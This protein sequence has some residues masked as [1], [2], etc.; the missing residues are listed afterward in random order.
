MT[1]QHLGEW[2][3]LSGRGQFLVS[4]FKDYGWYLW[5]CDEFQAPRSRPGILTEIFEWKFNKSWIREIWL[6]WRSAWRIITTTCAWSAPRTKIPRRCWNRW[7]VASTPSHTVRCSA[8]TP[9]LLASERHTIIADIIGPLTHVVIA[10]FTRPSS[11]D[12]CRR[13]GVFLLLFVAVFYAIISHEIAV[14]WHFSRTRGLLEVRFTFQ[15][16]LRVSVIK[17]SANSFDLI[18]FN[19]GWFD[20]IWY[21]LL[22]Y[23]I[24]V[25]S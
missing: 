10:T 9:T 25:S 5:V 14:V 13:K 23:S 22:C 4:V 18:Y 20:L 21:P 19:L 8:Q 17:H 7:L 6:S 3:K 16:R 24:D 11:L 15:I 12:V 1:W 2:E